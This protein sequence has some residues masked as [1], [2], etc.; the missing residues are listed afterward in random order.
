MSQQWKL[1]LG[2]KTWGRFLSEPMKKCEKCFQVTKYSFF[3]AGSI[4]TYP[5][6]ATSSL[7]AGWLRALCYLAAL[8]SHIFSPKEQGTLHFLRKFKN[9]FS[10]HLWSSLNYGK[11]CTNAL[12][13]LL[14]FLLFLSSTS[15]K[16]R[17]YF[18]PVLQLQSHF[19]AS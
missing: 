18:V 1:I 16:H 19:T 8:L 4:V 13:S 7:N 12:K 2:Q 3:T 17:L 15:Y 10:W 14:A 9:T 5:F 11:H 6:M